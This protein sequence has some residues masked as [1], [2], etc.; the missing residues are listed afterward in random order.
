MRNRVV[1]FSCKKIEN[2]CYAPGGVGTLRQIPQ[3]ICCLNYYRFIRS[4]DSYVGKYRTRLNS[5]VVRV[6]DKD[7]KSPLPIPF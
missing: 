2:A 1:F 7:I 3:A 5:Y 4:T 6:L